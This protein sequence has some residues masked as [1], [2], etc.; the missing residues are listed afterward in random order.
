V[1]FTSRRRAGDDGCAAAAPGCLGAESV[2]EAGGAGITVSYRGAP[3]A[4]AH[5][6]AGHVRARGRAPGWYAEHALRVCRVERDSF[7]RGG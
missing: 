5:F 6:K 7:R 3:E 1:I 4:I 2:R